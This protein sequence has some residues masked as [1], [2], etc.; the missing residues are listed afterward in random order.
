MK[1]KKKITKKKLKQP[2]EFIS[3]TEKSYLFIGEH[4]EKIS[5]GAILVLVLILSFFL[6]WMWDQRKEDEANQK[7]MLALE[8][9]QM[10]SSPYREGSPADYK[11]A[12]EGFEEVIKAYSRTSSA[13]SSLI[14][15]GGI[16]LR[17]SE[18]DEAINAYDTF[19]RK[20][21]QERLYQLFALEGL[22]YA[23]EGKKDYEKAVKAYQEIV[24]FGEKYQWA[25]IHLSLARCYE[26]LG[27]ND[28]ALENYKAFLKTSPKSLSTNSVLKKVS[29][30]EK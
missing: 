5:V 17:L 25:G 22:G 28:E 21:G 18:F 23:H 14:Y 11:K 13:K 6:F 15:K 24:K 2:D 3:F 19:L 7:F 16:H 1:I 29:V 12:L 9:Y 4:I 26:K 10:V 20:A 30:L 27:K 8:A